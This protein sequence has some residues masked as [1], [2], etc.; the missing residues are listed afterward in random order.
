MTTDINKAIMVSNTVFKDNSACYK[1]HLPNAIERI[2]IDIYDNEGYEIRKL[3]IRSERMPVVGDM[4]CCKVSQ[5]GT[6]HL[7][8]NLMSN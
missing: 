7:E 8:S 1:S 6:I 5:K 2:V 4:F 3:R